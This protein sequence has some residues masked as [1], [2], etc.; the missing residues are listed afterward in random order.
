M[1]KNNLIFGLALVAL[2]IVAGCGSKSPAAPSA[3]TT[4]A[5][6]PNVDAVGNDISGLAT[7]DDGFDTADIDSID[8]DIGDIEAMP[9]E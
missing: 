9:I 4:S 3:P 7:A 5:E 8:T 6:I 2:L 1:N